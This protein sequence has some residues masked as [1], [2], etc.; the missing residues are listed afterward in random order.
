MD[1]ARFKHRH[2]LLTDTSSKEKFTS[3]RSGGTSPELPDRDRQNH[4]NFLMA[5]LNRAEEE[6]NQLKRQRQAAGIRQKAGR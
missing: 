2:I 5:R 3:N 4:R 1:D 6:L